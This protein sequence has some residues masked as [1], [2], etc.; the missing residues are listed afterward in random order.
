MR[1]NWQAG[2]NQLSLGGKEAHMNASRSN[3]CEPQ[4]SGSPLKSSL[5]ITCAMAVLA[6]AMNINKTIACFFISISPF[7]YQNRFKAQ[8]IDY[9]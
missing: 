2:T 9:K 7:D 5:I 8:A 6:K 1:A 4:P 3:I